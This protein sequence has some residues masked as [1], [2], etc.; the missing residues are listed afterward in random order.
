MKRLLLILILLL[1]VRAQAAQF[2]T[3][4]DV[5][6][7][8]AQAVTRAKQVTTNNTFIAVVDREGYVL[9]VW[10]VTAA[11]NSS[12]TDILG[13]V[14]LA[15]A[16]AGTAAFLSSDQHAFSTRTAGFIVQQHFP[17]GIDNTPN[18]PLVGVNFSNLDF[19]DINR[20]KNPSGY[21]PAITNGTNGG[22]V[23]TPLTGG[24][25]GV[26]GGVPLYKAGKLVGGVGVAFDAEN[27]AD[28]TA[29]SVYVASVLEDI[30][31]AGQTG[32]GPSPSIYGSR[33]TVGGIRFEYIEST[34]SLPGVLLS[35]ASG[36]NGNSLPAF[37]LTNSPSF[38]YPGITIG[39]VNGELRIPIQGDPAANPLGVARLSA[40]EVTNILTAGANRARTTRAGIR[41]PRG[42]QMQCFISVI[43]NPGTNG[44]MPVVLGSICTS[45]DATR[46]SWDVSVQKARTALFFSNGTRAFSSRTVGFMAQ[47]FYPPGIVNTA[48]GIFIGLQE[49]FSLFPLAVTNPLNGAVV[50]TPANTATPGTPNPNLPNGI[51]IFPGGFPLYRNGVL[52]GAV[53][54]SGDGIDQDDIVAATGSSLFPPPDGIRA[55]RMIYRGARLPY[56]KFPRNPAL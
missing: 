7:V 56:A 13:P 18:G 54:V 39:G 27:P 19:S 26:A 16:K 38:S 52:I 36:A 2:M 12:T 42:T 46:F 25:A 53:G 5:T 8:I 30:A 10:S 4:T 23:T 1:A 22:A 50:T 41:Q 43:N 33:V 40:T 24:L 3:A 45:P 28:I 11:G 31:L 14:P 6:N 32:L 37:P 34:T 51:T 15:I 44:G 9:G 21:N 35:L 17:P 55:D 47:E 48:P 20:Y 49:R 29:T